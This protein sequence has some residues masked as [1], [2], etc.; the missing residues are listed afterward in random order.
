M[1]VSQWQ[2]TKVFRR[3]GAVAA[4]RIAEAVGREIYSESKIGSGRNDDRADDSCTPV[5][6]LG[7]AE[8]PADEAPKVW[9]LEEW[10]YDGEF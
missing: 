8:R 7:P 1:V 3:G 5:I 4:V 10:R 6:D 9:D 2:V